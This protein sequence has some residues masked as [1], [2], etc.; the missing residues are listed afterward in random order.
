M[1]ANVLSFFQGQRRMSAPARQPQRADLTLL[2][3]EWSEGDQA[4]LDRLVPLVDRELR[5]IANRYLRNERAN[6]T[7]DRTTALVNEAY[8][9]LLRQASIPWEN[10]VH[11]FGIAARLMR[12]ILVD[13]ARRHRAL[14][15]G[16]GQSPE[17]LDESTEKPVQ[18]GSLDAADIIDI[19]HALERLAELDER[20]ARV[21]EL[22]FFGGLTIDETAS[23]LAVSLDTV[24]RDWRNARM[25]LR[26]ELEEG[27]PDGR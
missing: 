14:K 26:R 5:R 22:R 15:R 1:G 23:V 11:F 8:A 20:Q 17:T 25:W 4:A 19:H 2:L 18:N 24:K 3:K 10:R 12:Q 6:P 9:G 16:A 27:S 21:V 7:L 13:H